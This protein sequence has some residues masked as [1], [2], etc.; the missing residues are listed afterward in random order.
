MLMQRYRVR[1][2]WKRLENL[3]L[4]PRQESPA[5]QSSPSLAFV[6][7][8]PHCLAYSRPHSLRRSIPPDAMRRHRVLGN[9]L[10]KSPRQEAA[11]NIFYRRRGKKFLGPGFAA[12]PAERAPRKT[13]RFLT[14]ECPALLLRGFVRSA[15][16]IPSAGIEPTLHPPQ[17]CVL[18]VERR[19]VFAQ[20]R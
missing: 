14:Q 9:L 3:L 1:E 15:H 18:S 20:S 7:A 16:F 6:W 8:P 5:T 12:R 17:G 11:K 2:M 4:S 13:F 10:R 19:G